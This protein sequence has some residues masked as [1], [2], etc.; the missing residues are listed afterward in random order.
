MSADV[1]IGRHAVKQFLSSDRHI[2]KLFV[3]EREKMNHDLKQLVSHARNKG[4]N[5]Q[6]LP[7]HKF[8][9]RFQGDHQGVACIT[10]NFNQ[11]GLP[12]VIEKKPDVILILDHLN[13]PHNFGAICRSA[14]TFGV[15]HIIYPKNR[16]VQITPV[17]AKSSAGAIENISFTQIAN[18][19]QSI[20][21]LKKN[22]YW[23][24]GA[25]SNKGQSLEKT[26]FNYPMVLI[27]GSEEMGISP[28]LNKLID[29]FIHISMKGKT[30]SLNV[31]VATG[32]I[33]HKI[34]FQ[35]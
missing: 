29:E 13:D 23:I 22:G 27:C 26:E 31:S 5:V 2:E 16:A 4:V 28:G 20:D 11:F 21:R 33:L 32:I 25:S 3:R 14:E 8:D 1:I 17:V 10:H 24:Y 34:A 19:R 30:S 18:L 35:I 9:E 7:P 15:E 12:D 6:W